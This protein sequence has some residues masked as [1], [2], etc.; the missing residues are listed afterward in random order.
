MVQTSAVVI[1]PT[2]A[3][4]RLT[5]RLMA[6]TTLMDHRTH[7]MD[8]RMDHRMAM[9]TRRTAATLLTAWAATVVR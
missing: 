1:L 9:A 8:R 3:T 7:R 5:V 6:A 4:G 2:G